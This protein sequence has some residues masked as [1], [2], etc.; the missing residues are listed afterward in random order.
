MLCASLPR[1]K[2]A[3]PSPPR[4]SSLFTKRAVKN[5]AELKEKILI[6]DIGYDDVAVELV[7]KCPVHHCGKKPIRCSVSTP[8]SAGSTGKRWNLPCFLPPKSGAGVPLHQVGGVPPVPRGAALFG[9]CRPLW[10]CPGRC[11]LGPEI[12]GRLSEYLTHGFPGSAGGSFFSAVFPRHR[13]AEKKGGLHRLGP[14]GSAG[15]L[16]FRN[17][18]LDKRR[19]RSIIYI[20]MGRYNSAFSVL[21]SRCGS[22]KRI[23]RMKVALKEKKPKNPKKKRIIL[24]VVLVAVVVLAVAGYFHSPG[25][26]PNPLSSLRSRPAPTGRSIPAMWPTVR[27]PNRSPFTRPRWRPVLRWSRLSPM[28]MRRKALHITTRMSQDR[29]AYTLLDLTREKTYTLGSPLGGAQSLRYGFQWAVPVFP[30]RL[31]PTQVTY[32][33]HVEDESIPDY[34]AYG[35]QPGCGWLQP[36]AGIPAGG[37]G[38][39][40][41]KTQ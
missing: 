11:P 22:K 7:K 31:P 33:V 16:D 2:A 17:F 21:E 28:S 8:I 20:S 10:L 5:L 38:A 39:R 3:P 24:L 34:T 32:T 40:Y 14:Q 18:F 19:K 9:L 26:W 36:L 4:R 23:E 41:G 15:K 6:F 30:H 1:G 12:V 13:K 35:E 27:R 25:P 29:L 37:V